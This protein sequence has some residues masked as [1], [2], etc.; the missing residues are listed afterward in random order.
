MV[1]WDVNEKNAEAVAKSIQED[2]GVKA[3]AFRVDVSDREEIA[4]AAKLTRYLDAW[5]LGKLIKE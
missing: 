1:I 5:I 2:T 3:K 4:K